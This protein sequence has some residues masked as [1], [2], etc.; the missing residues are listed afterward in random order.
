MPLVQVWKGRFRKGSAPSDYAARAPSAKS[1]RICNM[2][3]QRQPS[4]SFVSSVGWMVFLM[5]RPGRPLLLSYIA[6]LLSEGQKGSP[7][8]SPLLIENKEPSCLLD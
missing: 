7:P 1:A 4:M 2:W 5:P 8:V 3:Q 6:R